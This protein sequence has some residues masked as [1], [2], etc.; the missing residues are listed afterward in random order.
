MKN[1]PQK[2]SYAMNKQCSVIAVIAVYPLI[3]KK[4]GS[5]DFQNIKLALVIIATCMYII[6][7]T[8]IIYFKFYH[9]VFASDF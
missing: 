4:A 3:K 9:Y 7:I 6:I 5:N 1:A 8:F 2:K